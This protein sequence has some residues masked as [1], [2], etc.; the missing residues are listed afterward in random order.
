MPGDIQV[1]AMAEENKN[2]ALIPRLN[3]A[4]GQI[5]AVGRMI[6][7]GRSC[8]DILT[9][10]RAARAALKASED[11]ILEQHIRVCLMETAAS[12]NKKQQDQKVDILMK[13]IRGYD[14]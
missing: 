8:E 4:Q 7:E 9:Q 11:S 6:E 13:I 1:E 2:A 14:S 12:S 3:R 5:K 10:L